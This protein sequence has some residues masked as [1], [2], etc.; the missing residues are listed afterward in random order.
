MQRQERKHHLCIE[1]FGQVTIMKHDFVNSVS[2]KL[3]LPAEAIGEIALT[4]LRGKRSVHI[5]NHRGILEY[6]DDLIK[7]SVK[8]GAISVIGGNL[9]IVCMNRKCVEIRGSIRALELE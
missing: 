9:R 1:Y 2:E 5:E 4:E 8:R 6:S 7:I 3:S